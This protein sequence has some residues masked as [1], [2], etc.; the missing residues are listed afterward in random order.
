LVCSATKTED[1][2]K[3]TTHSYDNGKITLEATCKDA[4]VKTY[5]CTVCGAT[6]SEPIPK[7]ENHSFGNGVVTVQ[8]TEESEGVRT[9]TCSVCGATKTEKIYPLPPVNRGT[10]S[11]SNTT[12]WVGYPASDFCLK[13]TKPE[14]AEALS[15]QYDSTAL[16]IDAGK[17]TV[18]AL[19]SGSYLVRASSKHFSASFTVNAEVVDKTATD[20]NG[21]SK[22][23]AAAKFASRATERENIWNARGNDGT[24]T[25]FIGDS[26]FDDGFWTNF[27]T[28]EYFGKYDALRLGISATTTYDW[29]D[30]INGW[31]SKTNPRNIVMHMGTNNIYDDGDNAATATSALKRMFTMMHDKLPGVKIYW[32][33]ISQRSYNVAL[34]E[35]VKTVNAN[36]K[37]WCDERDYITY[38]HTVDTL[39][40]DMLKDSVH[41]LPDCY[42]V[43]RDALKKTDIQIDEFSD[44]QLSRINDISNTI[45]QT[46]ANGKGVHAVTYKSKNLNRNFILTGKLDI[47]ESGTNAHIQFGIDTGNNRVLLWDNDSNKSF[48]L[49]IPYTTSGIPADDTYTLESGKTLTISWKIVMTDDD[50]YFFIGDELKIV[51]TGLPAGELKLGSEATA[52]KFYDMTAKTKVDDGAAYDEAIKEYASIIAQY[53]SSAAG[54][55]R[56]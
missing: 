33:S 3:L 4:G 17:S 54:K 51:Y 5:T 56:V 12:A 37:V 28:E 14:H 26:F 53:G 43:F 27:Y 45:D 15:Y 2:E 39:T 52:V 21:S 50:M 25:A 13:F 23:S 11:I 10:L 1:I 48:L 49:C 6:E 24:T 55:I 30:W 46:I 31:L 7:T 18:K 19:K 41:P 42:Y 34:Q 29:E 22:W 44:E 8:P 38:I 9:Y 32:F 40:A 36:M 16:V 20:N 47:T 35:I